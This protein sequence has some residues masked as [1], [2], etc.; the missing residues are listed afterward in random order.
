MC[1]LHSLPSFLTPYFSPFVLH[2][3]PFIIFP[4]S[5]FSHFT[6]P[7][8]PISLFL[9]VYVS[10]SVLHLLP[11]VVPPFPRSSL[12]TFPPF[13]I[14]LSLYVYLSSLSS[15][16]S[17]PSTVRSFPH[18]S[19]S[20]F[21]FSLLSLSS[22]VTNDLYLEGVQKLIF[23]KWLSHRDPVGRGVSYVLAR[24]GARRYTW[25]T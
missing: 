24:T 19:L 14:S 16:S 21:P 22:L 23:L 11:L 3:L 6:F 1:L 7:R 25:R 8:F 20:S 2:L 15:T 18:S 9:Y 10:S 17:V 5:R 4:F 13:S 12:F